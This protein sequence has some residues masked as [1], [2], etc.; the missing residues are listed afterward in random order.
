MAPILADPPREP[1]CAFGTA[2]V[3]CERY[4]C[5]MRGAV[6]AVLLA[7]LSVASAPPLDVRV[8]QA[9]LDAPPAKRAMPEGCRLV[10]TS[11]R[12]SMTE[13]D[14]EGSKDPFHTQRHEAALAGANALLVL[15]KLVISRHDPECPGASRITD[16]PPGS[17]AWFD[18]VFESYAC[19][20]E[21]LEKL[22]RA[23]GSPPAT[24][25]PTSGR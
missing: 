10:Q 7:G 17:G 2:D 20:R 5:P 9:P 16:C 19:S 8:F 6:L 13:L 25:P 21:A 14:M 18:V 3:T 12:V 1:Q 15:R 22:S 11:K 23:T 24:S 4:T